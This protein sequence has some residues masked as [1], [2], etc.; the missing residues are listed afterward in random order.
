MQMGTSSRLLIGIVGLSAVAVAAFAAQTVI[1]SQRS[2]SVIDIGA[3]KQLFMDRRFIESMKGIELTMNAPWQTG[4]ILV[5]ADQPWELGD[6]AYLGFYS[7]VL[8]EE[9]KV[10]IWYDMFVGKGE[11]GTGDFRWVAYAE[12]EDGI[13]FTKPTLTLH[14][15]RGSTE[16]NVVIPGRIGG[17]AV[18]IDPQEIGGFRYKTQAKAYPSGQLHLHGSNDGLNWELLGTPKIGEKDTQTVVF[19]DERIGRYVM[20]T[21]DWIEGPPRYREHRRLESD[22]LL[23]WDNESTVLAADEVDLATHVGDSGRPAVDYYGATVF[24]YP[25]ADN[26]Y[27]M[28]AQTYWHWLY[29]PDTRGLGPDTFD[30]RLAVSR[31]G[32]EFERVGQ[33]KA[34]LRLGQ[35]GTFSSRSVWAMPQPIRMGDELWIYYVGLNK[36]HSGDQIDGAT[37][38]I[39][40][41]ISR[42]IMRL[43]GFVSADAAYLGGELTTPVVR[44][45]G[46]RLELNVDAGGGGAVR[47]ELLDDKYRPIA[48]F[49]ADDA[50]PLCANSVRMP[51]TWKGSG[52]VS[53]LSGQPVRLRFIMNDCK[54]Y[55]FQF[56][57]E[58]SSATQDEPAR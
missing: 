51:V 45:T 18:W 57:E 22:D 9:G 38:Q 56:L 49:S 50:D 33:R 15:M 28:F 11:R 19:W 6:H 26:A 43:D 1:D 24:K 47:V 58:P 36:D 42:A 20:F 34:F 8:K 2:Q 48:G 4:E 52:D 13:H 41:G 39:R 54:L 16:N 5:T 21:R 23:K 30:V 46:S 27:F 12:S 32:K 31:D 40:S 55:A 25:Y 10:R 44:F 29:R 7:S 3:R 37:G 53:A 35:E 17:S 14:E